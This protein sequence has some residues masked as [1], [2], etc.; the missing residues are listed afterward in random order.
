MCCHLA[1]LRPLLQAFLD[2]GLVE[3]YETKHSTD[4]AET[5]R[6][7][8]KYLKS[9]LQRRLYVLGKVSVQGLSLPLLLTSLAPLGLGPGSR[10]TLGHNGPIFWA[11]PKPVRAPK[12]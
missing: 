2:R 1:V 4:E 9:A 10:R 8:A 3:W 7:L 6:A 11:T 12:D 5:S